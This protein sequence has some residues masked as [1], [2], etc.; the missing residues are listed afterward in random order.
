[1]SIPDYCGDS[2]GISDQIVFYIEGVLLS[3]AGF[4]GLLGN[5]ITFHVLSRIPT[6]N[7]IFNKLLMQLVFG[8]SISIVFMIIDFSLRKSFQIFS[9]HDEGY[10]MIWPIMIYPL[11]KLS[12]TWI[13][14]CT[15]A[16]TIERYIYICYTNLFK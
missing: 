9:F 1:M 3:V 5:V 12:V 10:A 6:S 13:T 7:N 16:I 15:M 8:D 2:S 11:I 14:C 4:I